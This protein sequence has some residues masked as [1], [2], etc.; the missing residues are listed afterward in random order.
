MTIKALDFVV[1]SCV[2]VSSKQPIETPDPIPH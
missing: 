1:H 2:A